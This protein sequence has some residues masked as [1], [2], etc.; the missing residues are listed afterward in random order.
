MNLPLR[1]GMLILVAWLLN[2]R[3]EDSDPGWGVSAWS[4]GSVWSDWLGAN[5]E[6]SGYSWSG[7]TYSPWHQ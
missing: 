2:S 4:A 1:L 3:K 7:P 6:G 5:R